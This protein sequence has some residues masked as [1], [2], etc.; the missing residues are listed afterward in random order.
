VDPCP[1]GQHDSLPPHSWSTKYDEYSTSIYEAAVRII[2]DNSTL[3]VITLLSISSRRPAN[4][5]SPPVTRHQS[6]IT[7]LDMATNRVILGREW[8]SQSDADS[9]APIDMHDRSHDLRSFGRWC[10][11]ELQHFRMSAVSKLT[12]CYR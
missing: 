5:C 11:G 4:S 9:Q 2:K 12:R 6:P 8:Q 3:P 1:P 7:R 10:L